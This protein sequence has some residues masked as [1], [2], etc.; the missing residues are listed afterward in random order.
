M[1]LNYKDLEFDK[2]FESERAKEMG[3]FQLVLDLP[4]GLYIT[5]FASK[6][7]ILIRRFKEEL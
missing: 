2:D 5:G 7:R 4:K 3:L 1:K 6:N